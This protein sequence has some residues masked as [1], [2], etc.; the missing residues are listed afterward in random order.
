MIVYGWTWDD[1][2]IATLAR[3]PQHLAALMVAVVLGLALLLTWFE[4][5][6]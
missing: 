3:D 4:A 5:R 6:R 1:G 2:T